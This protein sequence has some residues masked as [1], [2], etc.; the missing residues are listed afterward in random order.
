MSAIRFLHSDDDGLLCSS[1]AKKL[2]PF[3]LQHHHPDSLE[4]ANRKDGSKQHFSGSAEWRL[5]PCRKNTMDLQ[6][7]ATII[8][9]HSTLCV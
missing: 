7:S 4:L 5:A 1:S 6:S 9:T 2:K 3:T 8:S